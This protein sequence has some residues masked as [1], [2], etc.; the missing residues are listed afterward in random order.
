MVCGKG[1]NKLGLR[2]GNGKLLVVRMCEKMRDE[3]VVL[4]K[5]GRRR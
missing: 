4:S 5:E 3:V 1:G 2:R